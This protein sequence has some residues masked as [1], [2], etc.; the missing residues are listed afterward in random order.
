MAT[1]D[2]GKFRFS[3]NKKG[4]NNNDNTALQAGLESAKKHMKKTELKLIYQ[5]IKCLEAKEV[6]LLEG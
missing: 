6:A 5:A 2:G 3:L 1:D 4:R